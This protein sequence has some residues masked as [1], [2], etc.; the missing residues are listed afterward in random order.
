MP[1]QSVMQQD[2]QWA[3]ATALGPPGFVANQGQRREFPHQVHTRHHEAYNMPQQSVMQQDPQWA[4]ATALGPPGFVANQGQCLEFPHRVH[5]RHHEAYNM[6]QQSVMQQA[7]ESELLLATMERERELLGVQN[8]H[9]VTV[10]PPDQAQ[11]NNHLGEQD[12]NDI[13]ENMKG[14]DINDIIDFILEQSNHQQE[15]IL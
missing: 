3:I 12:I 2:P 5:K 10:S 14:Q 13:L 4:I 8:H 15:D 7:R 1:Q 6:P 9:E 11:E